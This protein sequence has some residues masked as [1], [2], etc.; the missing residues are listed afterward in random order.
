MAYRRQRT[1]VNDTPRGLDH[2]KM[3]SE[4]LEPRRGILS[5]CE[6][7]IEVLRNSDGNSGMVWKELCYGRAER[8]GDAD[9]EARWWWNNLV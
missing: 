3:F 4:D 6:E 1:Y 9:D 8:L 7:S 2:W 5:R